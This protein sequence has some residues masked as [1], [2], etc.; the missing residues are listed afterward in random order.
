VK[1]A[2]V[3]GDEHTLFV[4]QSWSSGH[5][6]IDY[7]LTFIPPTI[8]HFTQD[9][10]LPSTYHNIINMESS[11]DSRSAKKAR[12]GGT[13]SVEEAIS[14]I[15]NINIKSG[16]LAALI[17]KLS[18]SIAAH[19]RSAKN[20]FPFNTAAWVEPELAKDPLQVDQ[21]Q[22]TKVDDLERLLPIRNSGYQSEY[23]TVR[24]VD[25]DGMEREEKFHY[26]VYLGK[27]REKL[28]VSSRVVQVLVYKADIYLARFRQRTGN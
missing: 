16:P 8:S 22:D 10:L 14:R 21:S 13:T 3:N 6:L 11:S 20:Y 2:K 25:D 12:I 26:T 4:A 1:P 5:L 27:Q 24:I 9:I 23:A 28:G 18:T 17:D 15:E 19:V 7:S